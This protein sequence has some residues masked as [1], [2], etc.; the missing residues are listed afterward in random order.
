ML[1]L[2]RQLGQ[3]D[4]AFVVMDAGPEDAG[5]GLAGVMDQLGGV[6]GRVRELEARLA[7]EIGFLGVER[8][9][10]QEDHHLPGVAA[11]A[12]E[13]FADAGDVGGQGFAHRLEFG[14]PA[15][16]AAGHHQ[17]FAR[18]RGQFERDAGDAA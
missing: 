13:L 1:G 11:F 16:E 8:A 10:V 6:A 3:H 15:A 9:V 4:A 17:A 7:A 12:A 18:R 5:Q 14:E 2:G